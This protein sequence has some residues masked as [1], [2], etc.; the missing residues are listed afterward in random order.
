MADML[1]ITLT[2]GLAGQ[3]RRRRACVRGLGLRHRQHQVTVSET[4]ENLGM[5]NKI[6]DMVTVERV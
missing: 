1:R 2:R 5:I 6:V 4:P 3:T